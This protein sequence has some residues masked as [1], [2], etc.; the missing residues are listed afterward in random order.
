MI[1]I[2]R[3]TGATVDDWPQFLQRAT[4]ALTTPLGTRQ[5]RPLYGTNATT[6]LGPNMT[7]ELLM[8]AQA[9]TVEA[10]YNP[11]NGIDDFAPDVVLA[12]RMASGLRLSIS[13]VWHNRKMS[14]EVTT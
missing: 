3:E 2:D 7:D 13:G 5:K 12:T 8:L 10:F 6:R 4:K 14:F 1:G 11:V 9:D